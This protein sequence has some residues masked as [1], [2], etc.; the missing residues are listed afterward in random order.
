M[1]EAS[2]WSSRVIFLLMKGEKRMKQLSKIILIVVLGL[3]CFSLVGCGDD[4]TP[5]SSPDPSVTNPDTGTTNQLFSIKQD[6]VE[7]NHI[8]GILTCYF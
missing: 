4:S 5:T 1:G 7:R 3:L 2:G 8:K 6:G